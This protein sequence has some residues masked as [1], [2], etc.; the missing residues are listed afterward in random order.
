MIMADYFDS[1]S[2]ETRIFEGRMFVRDAPDTYD[3]TPH[4]QANGLEWHVAPAIRCGLCGCD[5]FRIRFG[6]WECIAICTECN[7]AGVIY[8]G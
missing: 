4:F 3:L 7:R 8:D 6:D 2:A 1:R 5:T